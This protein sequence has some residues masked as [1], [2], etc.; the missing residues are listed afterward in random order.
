MLQNPDIESPDMVLLEI[1]PSDRSLVT[2]LNQ[3]LLAYGHYI[4]FTRTPTVPHKKG[5]TWQ[6]K[7]INLDKK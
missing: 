3:N 7:I 1:Q 6:K 4:H 5:S 2:K